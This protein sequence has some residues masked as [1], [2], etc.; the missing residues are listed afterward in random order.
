MHTLPVFDNL[1][2]PITI[3]RDYKKV[4]IN[5]TCQKLIKLGSLLFAA[6]MIQACATNFT[7]PVNVDDPEP[8]KQP[9]V[10]TDQDQPLSLSFSHQIP[11][12]QPHA[13]GPLLN[14]KYQQNEKDI[15][16]PGYFVAALNQELQARQLPVDLQGAGSDQLNLISYETITHRK[17]GFSPLVMIAMVKAD[18][19]EN[20]QTHR[21]TALVK[22]AKVPIWT[23]TEEPLIEATINQPQELVIKEV[24]AKINLAVFRNQLSDAQVAELIQSV[25]QNTDNEDLAYQQVYELGF[26]NNAKALPALREFSNANAEY[27]R[28]A[29]ISGMGM[30]GGEAVFDELKAMY[31]SGRQ[32]QDRAI[33]LKAIGDIQSA[34]ALDFLRQEQKKW[35]NDASLEGT[36]NQKVIALYLD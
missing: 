35:Q 36:W 28:L 14:Y 18:L 16:T 8:S 9:F 30:I 29:A 11:E 3:I 22:R 26:S 10:S 12:N 13:Q 4:T 20:N 19:I 1:Q 5:I 7:F 15:D 33:A 2:R 25:K 27:I 31:S 21:I 6:S 34:A 32:W 24:A 23:V 17:N